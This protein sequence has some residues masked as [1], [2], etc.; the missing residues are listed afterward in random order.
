MLGNAGP[1]L[2]FFA[3]L[4]ALPFASAA[5]FALT[6]SP[7]DFNGIPSLYKDE[8]F[9]YQVKIV[10]FG[11]EKI[12]GVHVEL[13]AEPELSII[14]NSAENE[15]NIEK[16]RKTF[17]IEQIRPGEISVTDI[18]VK[19]KAD[20]S[21]KAILSANYGLFDYSNAAV[22]FMKI[23]PSPVDVSVKAHKEAVAP[24]E[25]NELVLSIANNSP[26]SISDISAE[27]VLPKDL[28][29][30]ANVFT[31]H[32]LAPNLRSGETQFGFRAKEL[33]Q[34]KRRVALLVS[35]TDAAGRHAL[36]K[37]IAI[38][39]KSPDFSILLV[40][41]AIAFIIGVVLL[42]SNTATKVSTKIHIE[43]HDK[44]SSSATSPKNDKADAAKAAAKP[45]TEAAP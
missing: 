5:N 43:P 18:L 16:Q 44:K 34:G 30:D 32:E 21:D 8:L 22:A 40:A 39:V 9:P 26:N 7:K 28:E 14:D 35:F 1:K 3:L 2:F 45:K 19:A 41:I 13:N 42:S 27:L 24:L 12:T 6:I 15:A 29:S 25:E 11:S 33:A 36:D 23:V 38:D 20:N 17:I 4:A 31:L 37:A 10:N